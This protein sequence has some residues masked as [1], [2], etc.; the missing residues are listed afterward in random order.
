[1]GKNFMGYDN[2]SELITAIGNKIRSVENNSYKT[3][4]LTDNIVRLVEN[5]DGYAY[6]TSTAGDVIKSVG[7]NLINPTEYEATTGGSHFTTTAASDGSCTIVSDGANWTYNG[8]VSGKVKIPITKPG[9]FYFVCEHI[10]GNIYVQNAPTTPVVCGQQLVLYDASGTKVG[11]ET[12]SEVS[13]LAETGTVL[14]TKT[15]TAEQIQ[16]GAVT[17]QIA[18]WG[19]GTTSAGYRIYDNYKFR[20]AA[21]FDDSSIT[22]D[23]PYQQYKESIETCDASGHCYIMTYEDG[24][25]YSQNDYP[26][27]TITVNYP[28]SD[29][30]VRFNESEEAAT[31]NRNA[32]IEQVDKGAKNLLHFDGLS[33]TTSN[34][35]TFKI[36]SDYSITATR[37]T[38]S[39]ST[40]LADLILNGD[41][42]Y[43]NDWCDGKHYLSGC[44]ENGSPTTYEMLA[45]SYATDDYIQRDYGN[46][47]L[48][49]IKSASIPNITVRLVVRSSF[50]GAVTFKPM[51]CTKA[52]FGVSQ[53]FVP[54]RGQANPT[55]YIQP[56]KDSKITS[57]DWGGYVVLPGNV[58]LFNIRCIVG[59]TIDA[60]GTLFTG[61]PKPI[62]NLASAAAAL[63]CVSNASGKINL[64]GDGTIVAVDESI[65]VGTLLLSGTYLCK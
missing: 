13:F 60:Y 46:G 26:T 43:A 14:R 45:K 53:K 36:N 8:Y 27:K 62:G 41:L 17:L 40:A 51:I 2:A 42:V 34:G 63:R 9:T 24:S 33:S 57:I 58:C 16:A 4:N 5:E 23:T 49:P 25:V 20:I 18:I 29:F 22:A 7:K 19:N 61:L 21:Y 38:A 1:M 39:S 6:I 31:K 32:L 64:R 48:L 28:E 3:N 59:T 11:S 56:T 10:S 47:V 30:A 50:S 55:A 65:P 37:E 12:Y 35:V 54:Y 44:P 15:I 52:A